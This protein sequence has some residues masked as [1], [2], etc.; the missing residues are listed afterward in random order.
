MKVAEYIP[1]YGLLVNLDHHIV[2]ENQ[3][4]SLR[5]LFK[6][7]PHLDL[8]PDHIRQL[9]THDLN[10]L[11]DTLHQ[12]F[13]CDQMIISFIQHLLGNY[14]RRGGDILHW[15]Q[16]TYQHLLDNAY[17]FRA[18]LKRLIESYLLEMINLLKYPLSVNCLPASVTPHLNVLH[19]EIAGFPPVLPVN[20]YKSSLSV[21]QPQI[22]FSGPAAASHHLPQTLMYHT[23]LES[24]TNATEYHQVMAK[25]HERG[26]CTANGTWHD[27][28]S[29][30]KVIMVSL[31]KWFAMLNFCHKTKFTTTEIQS[32]CKNTFKT[33][34]I[35]PSTITHSHPSSKEFLYLFGALR[36]FHEM[37]LLSIITIL[38]DL[39]NL[40]DI[41]N[42]DLLLIRIVS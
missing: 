40:V 12:I 17:R 28:R 31:I 3:Q 29:G 36:R 30:W 15:L 10:S 25:L 7:H 37:H 4:F 23:L 8:S 13:V 2:I 38:S 39:F 19:P 16:V 24:F 5:E 41:F 33:E 42:L 35:S 11:H 32:I 21:N 6:D 34:E 27:H 14:I 22:L 20:M 18:D 26:F 1:M 9:D